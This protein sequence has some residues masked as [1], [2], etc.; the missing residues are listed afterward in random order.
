MQELSGDTSR[1]TYQKQAE[2]KP[3]LPEGHKRGVLSTAPFSGVSEV[4][5]VVQGIVQAAQAL[6]DLD[7]CTSSLMADLLKLAKERTEAHIV[8]PTDRDYL[9]VEN[10]VLRTAAF[11]LERAAK[12]DR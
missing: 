4:A 7:K 2:V 9:F 8:V 5:K 1:R 10:V 11:M 6:P 12:I 3:G